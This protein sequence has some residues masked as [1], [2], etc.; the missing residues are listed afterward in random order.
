[1]V[2]G[3]TAPSPPPAWS[4]QA[5]PERWATATT[6]TTAS[7]PAPPRP[8]ATAS[9]T[10]AMAAPAPVSWR[11]ATPSLQPTP[12]SAMPTAGRPL[13]AIWLLPISMA[14]GRTTWS[15]AP[16]T[17]TAAPVC[18]RGRSTSAGARS[19]PTCRCQPTPTSAC[20]ERP[21]ATTP[22]WSA[23]RVMWMETDT[24][25]CSWVHRTPTTTVAG[26]APSTFCWVPWA[27]GPPAWTWRRRPTAPGPVLPTP[28]T[29]A[30]MRPW[31]GT[32]MV[33]AWAICSWVQT[34]RTAAAAMPV[35]ST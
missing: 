8:A 22:G 15:A 29:W 10:I 14:M 30:R 19:S 35:R 13:A 16:V 31:E 34:R 6:G 21:T 23:A 20:R 25:T 32:T 2:G 27:P 5:A 3:W 11:V 1:M 7:I 9:T 24:P 12:F 17:R 26:R 4:P 18:R 33:M 28:I